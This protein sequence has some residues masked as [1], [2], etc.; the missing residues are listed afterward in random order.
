MKYRLLDFLVCPDCGEELNLNVFKEERVECSLPKVVKKCT[1]Y[2][3]LKDSLEKGKSEG[4]DC[5]DCCCIE[6]KEGVLE[7][8]EDHIFPIADYI[9]RMLP[10]AFCKLDDFLRK[11]NDDL[12]VEK[13]K[14]KIEGI[15]TRKFTRIQKNTKESFGYEWLRYDVDLEEEDLKVFLRDSQIIDE[16]FKGKVILDAGCG[17]GRYT[18]IAGKMGG[19]IVGIDLS[20]S[21]LKAYQLTQDNPFAYIIQ[22]DILHLPFRKRQFDIIYSLGVLHHTP[23]AE[24]S[25]YNLTRHLQKDGVISIWVYGTAGKYYDFK[26][27]P[28]RKDRQGYT[29]NNMAK[30]L[31]WFIVYIREIL[32]KTVR[33]VT[34]RMYVPVLYILCYPLAA[35]GKVPLLKYLTASVH[36]NWRV[37]L[38]ENFDWF[39]PQYQSHHT[40]EEVAGWFNKAGLEEISTLEHGLIPRV[41]LRGK[42]REG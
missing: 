39:S 6:I 24:K 28:L 42:L 4:I 31:H 25:F 8:K 33:L 34:T 19:E 41:G 2:C 20:Q 9:P 16:E 36:K 10:D 27:N 21:I 35:I 26:T 17:M 22:G 23:D 1:H 15:E 5:K 13:I 18:R 30:R 12:P 29:K 40:K 11:Y 3:A 37:R 38:L 14:K 7:C 32:F